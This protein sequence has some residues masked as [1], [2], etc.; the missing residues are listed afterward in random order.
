MRWELGRAEGPGPHIAQIPGWGGRL[1]STDSGSGPWI[2]GGVKGGSGRELA[3]LPGPLCCEPSGSHVLFLQSPCT[4]QEKEKAI[5]LLAQ[6]A[7]W[8]PVLNQLT[9]TLGGGEEG[10]TGDQKLR[11]L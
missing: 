11:G 6:L 2:P 8:L 10:A 7:F 3:C 9:A 4:L 1:E 5:F